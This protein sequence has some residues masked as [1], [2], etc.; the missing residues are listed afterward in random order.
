MQF[1]VLCK[2]TPP[3]ALYK[4]AKKSHI[5]VLLQ[6]LAFMST[7]NCNGLQLLLKLGD[8]KRVVEKT[9]FFHLA[10]FNSVVLHDKTPFA[11]LT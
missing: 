10:F 6:E 4:V 8:I 5:S 1:S 11:C 3:T 9:T 2:V 7:G